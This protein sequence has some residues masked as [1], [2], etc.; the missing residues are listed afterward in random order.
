MKSKILIIISSLI[1][2]SS[3]AGM[4]TKRTDKADEFLIEKKKSSRNASRYWRFA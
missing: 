3:C 1:I 4:G 2:L